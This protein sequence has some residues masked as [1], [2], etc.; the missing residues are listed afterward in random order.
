[1]CGSRSLLLAVEVFDREPTPQFR[2]A[3]SRLRKQ[4]ALS[5]RRSLRVG[6]AALLTVISAV[7]LHLWFAG[8]RNLN[9]IGPLFLVAVVTAAL[10]AIVVL[11]RINTMIAAAAALFAAGTLAA[12]VLSLLLPDGIFHFKEVGVSYS[13]GFAIAAELGVVAV[14]GTWRLSGPSPS[15][16]PPSTARSGNITLNN[17]AVGIASNPNRPGAS[18]VCRNSEGPGRTGPV[19]GC[20]GGAS[21]APGRLQARRT[22]FNSRIRTNYRL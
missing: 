17:P 11:V 5:A 18:S 6:T 22:M 16:T 20:A 1:M 9:T 13:G 21:S 14:L 4:Q 19:E 8:Y 10:L 7:H 3:G 12:N 2:H 15:G